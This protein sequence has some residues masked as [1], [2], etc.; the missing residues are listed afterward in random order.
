MAHPL[1]TTRGGG[2]RTLVVVS[3]SI[4]A[5]LTLAL[6]AIA[7]AG[8]V[9]VHASYLEPWEAGYYRQFADPRMQVVSQGV[10]APSGHNLQPWTVRLDSADPDV[11][12]LY[13]DARRLTPAVDPTSRQTMISQG[14]FL[15]Y[16][17]VSAG[18]LGRSM[19][20]ELF[21][22]GAYDE[23]RLAS[24][25]RLLP[26]AR[27]T[28]RSGGRRGEVDYGSLF[29][30][31]T[32]RAPYQE[33]PLSTAQ[34]RTLTTLAD[35][36]PA[37]LSLR[38]EPE[39]LRRIGELAVEGTRV[40]TEYAAATRESD[41]V[42]HATEASKNRARSGFAVEGQGTSGIKRYLLQGMLRIVPSLNDDA[43]AARNAIDLTAD[44]VAHTAAYGLVE[45]AGNSRAEQVG[46]GVLYA[47][48]SLR[49][50]TLGLVVQPLSQVLQEYPTMAGPRAEIHRDFAPN[51][52]TIQMLVRIGTPTR[53][54]PVTMRRD[55]STLVSSP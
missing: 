28:L 51:G 10:L 2:R 21:P 16:L 42:F 11:F 40:E 35:G 26:V 18:H 52:Q 37:T 30:S 7:T 20:V 5:T 13:A 53:E 49:A 41:A 6:G 46:A 55:P 48:L 34:R 43:A 4:V 15:A 3:V 22:E 1:P 32:N 54:Y 25:M 31:D 12:Y 44:G 17:G 38:T 9:L 36:S 24:S 23:S 39:D 19:S 50:R 14:A 47:R 33:E 8:G 27:I 45:T 29:R